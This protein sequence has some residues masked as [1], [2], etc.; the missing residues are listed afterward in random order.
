MSNDFYLQKTK[1]MEFYNE[2]ATIDG[3]KSRKTN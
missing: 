3:N 1:T 2:R